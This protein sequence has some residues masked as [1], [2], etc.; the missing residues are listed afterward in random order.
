[1]YPDS[2]TFSDPALA[3]PLH[4]PVE[5]LLRLAQY[6]TTNRLE[7]HQKPFPSFPFSNSLN[8]I[9]FNLKG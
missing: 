4:P 8:S 5:T 6:R 3:V 1:M 2:Q 7:D 9:F